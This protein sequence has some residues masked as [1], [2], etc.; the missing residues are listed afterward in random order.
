M[1]D[2]KRQNKSAIGYSEKRTLIY[3]NCQDSYIKDYSIMSQ[4]CSDHFQLINSE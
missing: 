4:F 3:Q 1:E 2:Y